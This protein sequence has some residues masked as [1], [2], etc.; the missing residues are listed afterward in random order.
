MSMNLEE[1]KTFVHRTIH[2]RADY[3]KLTTPKGKYQFDNLIEN[4]RLDD[5][6][7]LEIVKEFTKFSYE[8]IKNAFD[9]LQK[10]SDVLEINC[11]ISWYVYVFLKNQLKGQYKYT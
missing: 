11:N 9:A 5:Y 3:Y 4:T 8:K 2:F 10:R 1:Y 6:M 7:A